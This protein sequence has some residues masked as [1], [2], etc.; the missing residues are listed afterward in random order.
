MVKVSIIIPCY[1]CEKTIE[2]CINSIQNQ[3]F[4]DFE[5][6]LIDDGSTDNTPQIIKKTIINDN[7]FQYHHQ[8]NEGVSSARNHGL[9]K[10]KGEYI[11]FI[12]SDDYIE[13]EFIQ[14]LLKAIQKNNVKLSACSN[15]M[16]F[17][18]KEKTPKLNN[19][20]IYLN[21]SS[22]VSDK[23][24]H[25]SLF[26]DK[27]IRFPVGK[28]YE[29]LEVITKIIL[30]IDKNYTIINKPLYNYIQNKGSIMHTSDNRIFQIYDIL[31]N[32][33]QYSKKKGIYE[34][35]KNKIEFIWIY[36]IL[37][38]TIFRSGLHK[39]FSKE[40]IKK[41]KTK[42]T[43]K[44]PQWRKNKYIKKLPLLI[45]IYLFFLKHNQITIIYLSIKHIYKPLKEKRTKI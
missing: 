32:I 39:N 6:L 18:N 37:Y 12:D 17:K 5:A 10:I 31:E 22:S 8:K 45:R 15:K 41:I 26:E 3:S 28:W 2:R 27:D 16:I 4:T 19:H 44:Y 14:Q 30:N 23:L 7:R 20:D 35:N 34:K 29:D 24:F 43:Q 33:I 25:K 21:I 1:N 42:T 36:H 11:S 38:A 40:M 9:K 13:K